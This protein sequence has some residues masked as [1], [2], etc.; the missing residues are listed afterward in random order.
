MQFKL[1]RIKVSA[2]CKQC[3]YMLL[4]KV[5]CMNVWWQIYWQNVLKCLSYSFAPGDLHYS[6]LFFSL[7]VV[8][9]CTNA[10]H[11]NFFMCLSYIFSDSHLQLIIHASKP[12]SC[13][14]PNPPGSHPFKV[15][16]ER[17]AEFAWL[18][19]PQTNVWQDTLYK[20]VNQMQGKAMVYRMFILD[21]REIL[22]FRNILYMIS[23]PR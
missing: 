23:C 20:P 18:S 17:N 1:L 9:R 14:F 11:L 13:S 6:S 5:W 8:L 12:F 16:V 19:P 10:N 21:N 7:L 4:K 22:L 15:T 3:K 2:K